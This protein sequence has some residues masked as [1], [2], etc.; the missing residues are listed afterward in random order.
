MSDRIRL[1][2][3]ADGPA[4]DAIRAH[5]GLVAAE[6]LAVSLDVRPSGEVGGDSQPTGDG[7]VTVVITK[8]TAAG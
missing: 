7:L 3:G 6:T 5:A 2:I 1:T 8:E 4:G